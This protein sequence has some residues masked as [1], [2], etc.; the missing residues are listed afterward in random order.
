[1]YN[2]LSNA[3]KFTPDGGRIAVRAR[4]VDDTASWEKGGG[5]FIE[6]SVTDTG[7]GLAPE[8]LEKIF[9][10]FYQVYD[11]TRGKNPGTGL[12][13]SLSRRII[14]MHGG[15]IWAE[16]AGPGQGSAFIFRIPCAP[17]QDILQR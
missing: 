17:P 4:A 3:T 14:A 8:D 2:L 5:S 1:M 10:A 6:V 12:G 7:V 11:P 9:E 16:S 15:R 13:L